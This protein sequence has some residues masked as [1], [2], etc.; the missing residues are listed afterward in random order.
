[1]TS[2]PQLASTPA[3][4]R[5]LRGELLDRFERRIT[6][7]L[8]AEWSR[9]STIDERAAAPVEAVRD[10]VAAGGKRLRPLFCVS[11]FLA[12]GGDPEDPTIT[13]AA[14]ALELLHAFALI[15]DDVMDDSPLRRG[16]PTVHARYTSLHESCRWWGES[17]R[18][19]ESIAIIAGDLALVYADRFL[20]RTSTAV[21]ELWSELRAELMIGQHLDVALA[22]ERV[23]DVALSRWVAIGKSGRY[24]IQRPL[25]LGAL[26]AGRPELADAFDEYGLA[27][28]EAFQLRDDLLGAFGD[29][30]VA[31]KPVG[32]DVEQHKM[33]LLLAIASNEDER[34]RTLFTRG[35]L[36]E[37]G[38][39]RHESM[40]E[41]LRETGARDSVERR[42]DELVG[43]ADSAA[44]R[45]P[46]DRSWQD[47]LGR[48]AIGVAYRDS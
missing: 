3:S 39:R 33:T 42:I 2:A 22:A 41:L 28:G 9:W 40:T 15:H 4:I 10:L 5:R 17:R 18:F 1:M 29:A 12:C 16:R 30:A 27:L 8:A 43:R 24:T 25:A 37:G 35:A 44:R 13:D 19:G 6:D 21:L 23:T 48:L 26:I 11:G 45:L 32:A 31:G 38:D 20:P 36:A 14:V 7:F 34:L 47:E 46:L